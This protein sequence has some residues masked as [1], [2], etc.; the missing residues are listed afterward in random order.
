MPNWCDNTVVV[1]GYSLDLRTFFE[2]LKKGG[3][4]KMNNIYPTPEDDDP[5]YE[6]NTKFNRDHNLN[7]LFHDKGHRPEN[8]YEWNLLN[9]GTK[10]DW[11]ISYPDIMEELFENGFDEDVE[12]AFNTAWSPPV[13]FFQ[14]ASKLYPNLEFNHYFFE[15]GAF[16]FGYLKI[17]NGAIETIVDSNDREGVKDFLSK[18]EYFGQY[19]DWFDEPENDNDSEMEL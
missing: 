15:P 13:E 9:R 11:D 18:Y 12:I 8:W 16:F 5:I 4:F 3:E 17:Q 10:W 7:D 14:Y 6:E 2:D 19:S 1:R